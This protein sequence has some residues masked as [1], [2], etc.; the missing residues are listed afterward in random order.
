MNGKKTAVAAVLLFLATFFASAQSVP[1]RH[2]TNAQLTFV[3]ASPAEIE[4]VWGRALPT[5]VEELKSG[6]LQPLPSVGRGGIGF[7]S[8]SLPSLVLGKFP[9]VTNYQLGLW[10]QLGGRGVAILLAE[11]PAGAGATRLVF[12][13]GWLLGDNFVAGTRLLAEVAGPQPLWWWGVLITPGQVV[14]AQHGGA[15]PLT[16]LQIV[17]CDTQAAAALGRVVFVG[18]GTAY[19]RSQTFDGFPAYLGGGASV[20]D[21]ATG[22]ISWAVYIARPADEG[23]FV[24]TT[25]APGGWWIF[26]SLWYPGR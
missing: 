9:R 12:K 25:P 17:N 6:A 2:L 23:L 8:E 14:V 24:A 1:T 16:E 3:S 10:P 11:E 19:P 15:V 7:A 5:Q 26:D 4:K 21:P 13:A 22:L 20:G 18:R